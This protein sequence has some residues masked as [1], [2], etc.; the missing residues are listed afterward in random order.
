MTLPTFCP[1]P[2]SELKKKNDLHS[3]QEQ[4]KLIS[5][6]EYS[7]TVS[8]GDVVHFSREGLWVPNSSRNTH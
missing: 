7:D 6:R 5:V 1:P 3:L 2:V 4:V 8:I